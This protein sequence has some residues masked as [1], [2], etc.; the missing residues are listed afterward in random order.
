LQHLPLFLLI[1]LQSLSINF[2][3]V[4]VIIDRGHEPSRV[5]FDRKH[6]KIWPRTRYLEGSAVQGKILIEILTTAHLSKIKSLMNKSVE[7]QPDVKL[8]VKQY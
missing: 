4:S 2:Q 3:T 5:R 1:S 8:V 6:F 7:Q